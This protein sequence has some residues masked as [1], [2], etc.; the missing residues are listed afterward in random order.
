PSEQPPLAGSAAL[1][2]WVV[3]AASISTRLLP[4]LE[5]PARHLVPGSSD[6]AAA[7][8]APGERSRRWVELLLEE[9][10]TSPDVLE[11]AAV[12]DALAGR[13]GGSE[14]K[15]LD[16]VYFTPDRYQGMVR[17]AGIW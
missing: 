10:P 2:D 15:L 12:V 17:A 4:L 1:D 13:I 16:L 8:L 14:R 9:D 5:A 3:G 11:I 7:L 6:P